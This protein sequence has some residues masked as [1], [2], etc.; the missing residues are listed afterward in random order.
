MREIRVVDYRGK[1]CAITYVDGRRQRTSLGYDATS[2][3]RDAAERAAR[4]IGRQLAAPT[5]D[6]VGAIMEAYLADSRAIDVARLKNAWKAAKPTF[7]KLSPADVTRD[8][9]RQYAAKRRRAGRQNGTIA[10]EL[11]TVSAGLHWH[12]KKTPAVM[13]LPATPPPRDRWLDRGEFDRLLTAVAGTP[14]LLTFLHLAIATAGRKEALLDLTWD[15]VDFR[16]GIIDLG[17]KPNG[18]K[19]ARVPMTNTLRAALSH[20][21][22]VGSSD[23]VVEF[24]GRPVKSVR[25]A[26]SAA[27]RRAKLKDVHI[28]DLRHTAAVWMAQKGGPNVMEKIREYLGHTDLSTT[29]R[30]YARF[31]PGYLRDVA[32][33]L[34]LD[35]ARVV[36]MN[37]QT[38]TEG[39]SRPDLARNRNDSS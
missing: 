6:T 8:V 3:S 15:R 11:R 39:D 31:T 38:G 30:I 20:A 35:S 1:W 28:H 10:K 36:Q 17:T 26:F 27:V 4:S 37:Q 21:H 13:E 34:E 12:D 24:E 14:H 2:E 7:E 19:R 32:D 9:C 25:T 16:A 22:D 29:Y 33:A 23:H 18:K 5:D